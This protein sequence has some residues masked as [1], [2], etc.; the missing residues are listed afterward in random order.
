ME[1]GYVGK[2]WSF[3]RE[4]EVRGKLKLYIWRN[5]R[6]DYTCGIGFAVARNK[7]EAIESIKKISEDWEWNAYAGELLSNEPEVHDPPYGGSEAALNKARRE[8]LEKFRDFLVCTHRGYRSKGELVN[9]LFKMLDQQLA[10]IG[11]EK[12]GKD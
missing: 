11:G 5:I 1:K 4:G 9:Q 2:A 10:R 3:G 12:N 6:R 7:M 8:V